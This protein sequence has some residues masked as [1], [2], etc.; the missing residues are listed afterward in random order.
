MKSKLPGVQNTQIRKAASRGYLKSY[1][2]ENE[3]RSSGKKNSTEAMLEKILTVITKN[4]P[5][6][7]VDTEWSLICYNKS[8]NLKQIKLLDCKKQSM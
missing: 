7:N 1:H 2:N 6:R 4:Q 3:D 5:T 8:L